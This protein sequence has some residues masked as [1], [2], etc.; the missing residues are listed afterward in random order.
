MATKQ[1]TLEDFAAFSSELLQRMDN[2]EKLIAQRDEPTEEWIDRQT[3][4]K[5][6]DVSVPTIIR[7]EKKGTIPYSRKGMR[8]IYDWKK[9]TQALEK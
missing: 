3:L 5:R 9:V 1:Y 4:C 6:L 7:M 8:A 2:L